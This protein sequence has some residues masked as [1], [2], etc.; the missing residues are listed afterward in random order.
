MCFV[1]F[2]CSSGELLETPRVCLS[3]AKLVGEGF[4]YNYKYKTLDGMYDDMID[5]G[6]T[7]GILPE[8]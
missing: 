8:K 3:S 1:H 6:K 7:L 2:G 5:Y 4:D